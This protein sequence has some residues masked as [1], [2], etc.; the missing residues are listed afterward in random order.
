ML[1]KHTKNHIP[2]L[3]R[4]QK[5]DFISSCAAMAVAQEE[6]LFIIDYEMEQFEIFLTSEAAA[7]SCYYSLGEFSNSE[8]LNISLP[9]KF[10]FNPLPIDFQ[11]YNTA[12]SLVRKHI[13]HGNS[14]LLNLTFPTRLETDLTLEEIFMLSEAR[15]KLVM[16]DRFVVF[17]PETFIR[18][19]GT[20]ISTFPM[21]GTIDASLPGA[22][23]RIIENEKEKREHVT[24]VDLLRN[25][26]SMVAED[27][28]LERFRYIERLKTHKNELLQVS[29]EIS[30]K[31]PE[32][33]RSRL[34]EI[35]LTLLP[36]G[37]IC[38]APKKKTL[39]II[40]EAE[41][42]KRGFFTGIFGIC[43]KHG[44]DS[45]VLIRYIENTDE[46]LRFRSG[47]GITG[48][49]QVENEYREMLDKVYVP[50]T[51]NHKD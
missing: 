32:D 26:L 43:S 16:E 40:A 2:Y 20:Q 19:R 37:S 45:A 35:L 4:M 5:E 11:T 30:G 28:K 3:Y 21:K 14:F 50:F 12:F 25:D 42:R 29:S 41:G 39:E 18:I 15:Y 24:I 22:E 7:R 13:I 8:Q 51:G 38:G 10:K 23:S 17:S 33:W 31:L 9:D 49:S 27:V 36:A 6:F 34:G 44:V 46:G 47:G 48:E 1:R